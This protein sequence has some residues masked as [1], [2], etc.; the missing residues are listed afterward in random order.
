MGVCV[1]ACVSSWYFCVLFGYWLYFVKFTYMYSCMH[2]FAPAWACA[3]VHEYVCMCMHIYV[4]CVCGKRGGGGCAR[5]C[6]HACNYGCSHLLIDFVFLYVS[7][8]VCGYF[9]L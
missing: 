8:D 1:G 5:V 2:L 9:Y 3:R 7:I 4:T 6:I